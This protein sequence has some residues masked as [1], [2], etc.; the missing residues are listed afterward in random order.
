[1]L[2]GWG[3]TFRK[4]VLC[5]SLCGALRLGVVLFGCGTTFRA[6]YVLMGGALL[7]VVVLFG[8]GTTFRM[9]YILG[10]GALLLGR[11]TF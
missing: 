5:Y 9:W 11:G 10:G 8:C 3:I 6:W 7:L 1:M 4:V 2:F